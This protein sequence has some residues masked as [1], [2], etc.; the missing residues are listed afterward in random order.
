[1][2]EEEPSLSDTLIEAARPVARSYFDDSVGPAHDWYHVE[3]V[4]RLALELATERAADEGEHATD[5]AVNRR[6]LSLATLLHDIGRPGEETGEVDDHATWGAREARGI[7]DD[8]GAEASTI[9]SVEH[10][11][12]A[13]RYSNDVEPETIEAKLLSDADNLDALGAIGI[14]RCFSYGGENGVPIHDPNLPVESDP[15]PVG[16]TGVNHLRTKILSLPDRMYTS[17]GH[18]RAIERRAFVETFLERLEAE[19]E[20]TQRKM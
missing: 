10:A 7:L 1:M 18:R 19:C 13:H 12:R 15:D 9:R 17:A 2:I 8:L 6:I 11:I 3:R 20:G 5:E 16:S 14:A 4:E